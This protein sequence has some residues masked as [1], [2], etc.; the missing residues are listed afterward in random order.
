MNFSHAHLGPLADSQVSGERKASD[1]SCSER[2][3]C[4]QPQNRLPSM[5]R[6]H[7]TPSGGELYQ[8]RTSTARY[9]NLRKRCQQAVR[10]WLC[11]VPVTLGPCTSRPLASFEGTAPALELE[12]SYCAIF[13]SV[14]AVL[15]SCDPQNS[16]C[17]AAGSCATQCDAGAMLAPRADG[18]SFNGN[19]HDSENAWDMGFFS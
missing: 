13:R 10:G 19:D 2:I 8:A 5:L 15:L 18:G 6:A 12:E 3:L 16:L 11:G 4:D 7:T 17:T 14:Q 1:Q 9:W